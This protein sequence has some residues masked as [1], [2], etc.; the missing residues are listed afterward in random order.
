MLNGVTMKINVDDYIINTLKE[1]I[2][3]EDVSTNAVMPEDKQGRADLICKQDGIVCGLDVFERTFKIL[4]D[5]SRF[6]ANFKD[7]DFVKKGDLIGVI[8]GD[9]KAILSGERTALNYLQR[10]SGIAT[11]TREYV[12]ELKGYKTVLLDTRK[13]TPNMRPF[14][15][16]AVKVGGATNHR[17]NLSDGVLLKDN[18]IGAAGS[19]TKAIE[20]A[21]AYAPFVRKIEIE[22]ETLEQVKE[23]LD[24]GADIIMLDN[25]DNDTMRKAVEMIDG[26]AQ[27][28]CSGNVTK[29]RLK[30]IA[31]IGVDFVSCGA[32]THSAMI[33]D[34]SLK[35]LKTID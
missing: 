4:D 2:T 32:L 26:K 7:G 27:T 34:V 3:S 24:A 17:Y 21:K 29:E 33:M 15:K 16:H 30:E 13:T 25:M 6:E 20:M 28:E 22:T 11:M 12:N 19:V 9:V 35:N 18:H 8:Y 14:E 23:A 31:E 5:T 1:D 10:M